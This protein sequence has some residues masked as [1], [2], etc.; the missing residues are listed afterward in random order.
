VVNMS[1]GGGPSDGTDPL[2]V[3]L[4]DLS[5]QSG[6]LFV[7]A[8]GNLGAD[9]TVASP[10]SAATALTVGSVSKS[11]VLSPFSSRG[12]RIGDFGLKPEIVAPGESIVAAR[13]AA[14][15][16]TEAV[17][18][19]YARL[20]GTSM[21]TPHVSGA[22]A[23]LAGEHPT[24][25][26]ALLK[27]V[28]EGSA[29]SLNGVSALAQGAGRLDVARAVRQPVY[30]TTGALSLGRLAWPQ[31]G[32]AQRHVI[33]YRNDS[34]SPVNLSLSVSRLSG[35]K[36]PTGLFGLDR[37][38]LAVPAHTS[39][40]ATL[41]V[42]ATTAA[43]GQYQG[44]VTATASGL[45]LTTPLALEVEGPTY[46]LTISTVDRSGAPALYELNTQN[47]ET[48]D[49]TGGGSG[50]DGVLVLRV[51]AGRTRITGLIF[52]AAPGFVMAAVAREVVVKADT[53][54]TLDARA[55]KPV[56]D[57]STKHPRG[58]YSSHMD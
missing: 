18:D 57:R 40:D 49:F 9:A 14:T 47:T 33:N 3:A 54:I 37:T 56:Q 50:V 10:G 30:D 43:A 58:G 27:A 34:G 6:T 12:P 53:T 24:W 28:L 51:P 55:G 38:T 42:T 17:N 44:R 16:R 35:A 23:I 25:G 26:A 41:I 15:L 4:D 31:T 52:N 2:S 19:S 29:H 13:A 46:T 22:A 5:A 39:A 8:A 11:D 21:A 32:A 1:L 48:G 20:S 45:S 7:V 36:A